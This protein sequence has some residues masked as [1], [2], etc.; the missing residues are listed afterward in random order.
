MRAVT[1]GAPLALLSLLAVLVLFAA[2]ARAYEDQASVGGGVGYRL[3][4]GR[5]ARHGLALGMTFGRGIDE[6]W[7]LRGRLTHAE[8]PSKTSGVERI[9]GVD[10][11]L[12]YLVDVLQWV[13]YAG[14]GAGG[15][16]AGGDGRLAPGGAVHLLVGVDYLYSRTWVWGAELRGTAVAA[17]TDGTLGY[18][19]TLVT[20]RRL[21]ELW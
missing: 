13:P 21:F 9:V 18:L 7:T 12:I 8:M 6:V 10:V 16:L 15:V 2:P 14:V 4:A 19:D 20:V 3:G 17:S 11:D 1:P 5:L